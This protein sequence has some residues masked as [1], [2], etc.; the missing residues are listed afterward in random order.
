[1]GRNRVLPFGYRICS[2]EIVVD[3]PEA[4]VIRKVFDEYLAGASYA[5]IAEL[6]QRMGVRYHANTP[7]WNKQ[8]INRM[9]ENAKYTG[10]D[11]YPEI[12]S[13]EVFCRASAIRESKHVERQRK[14]SGTCLPFL[15]IELRKPQKSMAETRLQN[16]VTRALNMPI[17]DQEH[18]KQVIFDLAAERFIN[19][20]EAQKPINSNHGSGDIVAPF[21]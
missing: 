20:L 2:G 1:M 12:V 6:L 19:C 3:A 10:S 13:C 7:A 11:D 14:K 5:D 18:V 8:M 16:E 4:M 9:I 15:P 21:E 17:T